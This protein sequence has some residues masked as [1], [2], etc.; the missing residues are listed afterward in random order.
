MYCS[1]IQLQSSEILEELENEGIIPVG[2]RD[3]VAGEAYSIMVGTCY[4]KLE[5]TNILAIVE[6]F[7][8]VALCVFFC[9]ALVR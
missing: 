5:P 8:I 3:S 9:P 4:T 6:V 2:R 1:D 7:K